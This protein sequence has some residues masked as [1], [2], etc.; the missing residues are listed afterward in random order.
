MGVLLDHRL[1]FKQHLEATGVKAG[2]AASVLSGIMANIGG[3]RQRSSLI[4]CSVVRAIIMYAAQIWAPAMELPTYSRT[5]KAAYRRCTLRVLSAYRTVSEDAALVLAGMAPIDLL[6]AGTTIED[7]A[8]REA[9][10]QRRWQERWR[11]TPNGIWTRRIVPDIGPWDLGALNSTY[12]DLNASRI[13]FART[14]H[15]P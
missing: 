2:R 9:E 7:Q 13:R 8:I 15:G 6:A 3:P 10:T 11:N 4:I 14:V 1:S 5:C 12:I